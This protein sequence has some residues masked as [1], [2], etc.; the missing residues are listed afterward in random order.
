MDII[1]G[2]ER[3]RWSEDQKREIVA[4]TV[5]AGEVTS[6]ARR[7]GANPSMVFG[8]RKRFLEEQRPSALSSF[9]PVALGTAPQSHAAT[10]APTIDLAFA[11]GARLRVMGPVDADLV[12]G[13]V[14]ALRRA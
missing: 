6:V 10:E 9:M 1:L 8:W 12:A 3:K 5:A 4:E 13:I 11:C 7:H 14:K 2:K